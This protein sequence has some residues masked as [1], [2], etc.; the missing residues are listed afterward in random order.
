VITGVYSLTHQAMQLGYTPRVE[1][2]HTSRREAGQIYL[3]GMNWLLFLAVVALVLAFGSSTRLAAAYGIAVCGTMIITTVL[4]FVV[5]RHVWQWG[6]ARAGAVTLLFLT[7]DTA[8]L[9]A[10][11]SKIHDG[12]W[13]PLALGAALFLMMTT[14]KRGQQILRARLEE[15]ALPLETFVANAGAADMTLIPGTAIFLT[16]Q[17][18]KVPH[19]LLHSMK[20]FKGLHERIV[21]LTVRTLD[22]P[23]VPPAHRVR[24]DRL[25]AHFFRVAVA[26]GF[27]DEPDLPAVLPLCADQGLDLDL[28]QTSFFLGRETLLPRRGSSLSY[29]REQLFVAMFRNAGNAAAHFRL[30]PNRVIELGAQV[31]L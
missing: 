15:D 19:A 28:M 12:G 25:D 20:H 4:A 7:V 13:L 26:Y 27:M 29:W 2:Q 5:M 8:F 10:N 14:W 17:P 6:L 24:V 23:H 11:V 1:V 31:T 22:E 30:P 9:G 18:D 3:P 16:A 21:I